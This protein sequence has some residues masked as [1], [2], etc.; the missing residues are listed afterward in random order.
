MKVWKGYEKGVNLGG[1]LSQCNHT[2][3]RY[4]NFIVEEDIKVLAGWGADHLRLP[5][6]YDL[7][8]TPEGEYKEEGFG[9][10]Q[11]AIDWCGKYNLN[12][13]LDVH[14]TFGYSFDAGE[15]EDGFFESEKYQERFYR[16]WE[17]LADRFG[18]YTDRVAFELLNEVT[19]PSYCDAWNKIADTCIA[20]IRAIVPD[21]KILVGGYWNNSVSAVKDIK[22]S[23]YDNIIL[24]FHCYE[25]LLFTHQGAY[26]IPTMDHEFR[27]PFN[28]DRS[29]Y[30]AAM[31]KNLPDMVQAFSDVTEGMTVIT[32]EYFE[33]L[34][35]EAISVAADKDLPLYCG[36]SGVIN[37]ASAEDTLD[38][39]KAF[40]SVLKK[41][42]IGRA[43][44]SYKEMDFGLSDDHMKPT[45][46][47]VKKILFE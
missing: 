40:E 28:A 43:A 2:K 12:M 30:I 18:K 24:N 6:D 20:R 22:L 27:I 34:F 25:P 17:Q 26:W 39:Y 33:R 21:V 7:V 38:W 36:E 47:E 5:I 23:T 45:I 37:L 8:E 1:W 4:D 35:A 11:K 19:L 41:Y 44:W 3:E 13:V 9:Y 31:E 32:E 42:S 15:K 10:I 14:K 16:L 46:E 29:E